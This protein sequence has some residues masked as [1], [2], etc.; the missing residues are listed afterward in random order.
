MRVSVP[1]V[2]LLVWIARRPRSYAETAA[3]WMTFAS[4]LATWEAARD[5]G[6]VEIDSDRV[7]L[8]SAGAALLTSSIWRAACGLAGADTIDASG[9]ADTSVELEINGG[10]DA[11]TLTGSAGDDLVNGGKANDDA[12]LGPGNDTFVWNP[13]EG[14]DTIEGQDGRDSMLF[15]GANVASR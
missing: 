14:S 4:R 11:D 13:G 9:L 3:A 5:G 10:D 6:L 15:N 1:T 2:Q 8:T 7:V 12:L